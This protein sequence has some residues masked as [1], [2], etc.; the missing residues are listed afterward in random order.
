MRTSVQRRVT[1]IVIISALLPLLIVWAI[2]LGLSYD[3]QRQTAQQQQRVITTMVASE[4]D[5]F[6]LEAERQ[7]SVYAN[8]LA[9]TAD[10]SGVT[11]E[12][13]QRLIAAG[14]LFHSLGLYAP[15]GQAQVMASLI[16]DP[17]LPSALTGSAVLDAVQQG[18]P[19]FV[20][21]RRLEA[22]S[23]P[24]APD[25]VPHLLIA[26][27][28]QVAFNE[29]WVLIGTLSMDQIW[30][31]TSRQETATNTRITV[32][33]QAGNI[34]SASK[35]QVLLDQPPLAQ[36]PLFAADTAVAEYASPLGS[37][38]LGSRAEIKTLG[39]SAVVEQ[40]VAAIYRDVRELAL[41]LLTVI[42]LALPLV[43]IGGWVV[44]RRIVRP[45]KLLHAGVERFM[46]APQSYAEVRIDT[47][48]ELGA[49]G[50]A[51]NEM[52]VSINE[53]R[54]SLATANAGLE[55][56]IGTRTAQLQQ[57][58]D[59]VQAQHQTQTQL[60]ETVRGLSMPV[61]PIRRG[62]VVMPLVGDFSEQRLADVETHLLSAIERERARLVLLDLS[63]LLNADQAMAKTLAS[64]SESA[65]L[66]GAQVV[67]VGIRPDLAESLI[68]VGINQYG[69]R[70][71][72]NLEQA[73]SYI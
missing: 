10:L 34:V 71:A 62:V 68:S 25:E 57:A 24:L 17:R 45:I 40:P 41:S 4:V 55:D 72:A 38:V 3:S 39:W 32:L 47:R 46:S 51:F 69:V 2:A 27:P 30:N 37:D 48:D 50:A 31:V 6:V 61:I 33:D 18:Q 12:Q 42:V 44:G 70:T 60:L 59:E 8:S 66:L 56:L 1:L 20:A 5:R 36:T 15:T 13:L 21:P 16:P 53:S 49:L 65:R 43:A 23:L 35:I 19:F 67:L 22:Q 29:R 58:L 64:V 28:V 52:V 63:G 73:F 9:Q 7:L 14:S 26:V 11:A 54:A